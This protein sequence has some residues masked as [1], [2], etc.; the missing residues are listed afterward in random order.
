MFVVKGDPIVWKRGSGLPELARMNERGF[1]KGAAMTHFKLE[2]F[3]EQ[4]PALNAVIGLPGSD[5]TSPTA[6]ALAAYTIANKNFEVLGTNMTTALA[7]LAAPPITG[8]TLTTAG[9]D[10]DQ[11]IVTPH[12][13]ATQCVW[14]VASQWKSNYQPRFECWIA[15][16]AA[17]TKTIIRA[18]LALTNAFDVDI[19]NAVIDDDLVTLVYDS[20]QTLNSTYWKLLTSRAGV[21][22]ID[23]IIKAGAVAISTWYHIVIEIDSSLK[24]HLWIN[25]YDYTDQLS[26]AGRAA[27]VTAKA[28]IPYIGIAANGS[29]P[30]AKS[31]S[32]RYLSMSRIQG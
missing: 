8:I 25:G 19:S 32:V 22:T 15:T 29:A 28:F 10:A 16:A 30:G 11:A 4:R 27:L 7:T 2:E 13:D 3:F 1:Q 23:P 24:P 6:T 17:I 14:A 31:M 5:S 20:Q 12:L 9:A 18:G 26:S 21:D